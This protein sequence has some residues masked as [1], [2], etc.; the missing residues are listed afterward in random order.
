MMYNI[1]SEGQ[2]E[3][4]LF[5]SW[6]HKFSWH[7]IEKQNLIA[8]FRLIKKV[9]SPLVF[10]LIAGPVIGF[11]LRFFAS[12]YFLPDGTNVSITRMLIFFA[13]FGVLMSYV[14]YIT[15]TLPSKPLYTP[16][17]RDHRVAYVPMYTL[18]IYAGISLGIILFSDAASWISSI[19]IVSRHNIQ[20]TLA[21]C[22][23]LSLLLPVVIGIFIRLRKEVNRANKL[24]Y[25]S[26]LNQGLLEEHTANAQLRAL[27]A[28]INP[29]F[30]F[31]TLSSIVSLLSINTAVAKD[32]LLNLAEMHRYTL[33]C[34]HRKFVFLEEEIDFVKGYLSIEEV[35]FRDRLKIDIRI[36]EEI[37][38]LM[39]PGLVLQPIV[40]NAVKHGVA[41][42]IGSSKISVTVQQSEKNYTITVC[43]TT[44]NQPDLRRETCFV[45]GH[46]LK[47]VD[48]RL[49]AIYE[50][51]YRIDMEYAN[52]Q[53]CVKLR[54][55][56]AAHTNP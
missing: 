30:F 49:S 1:E 39:L 46:A 16:L 4:R 28:Q 54:I 20:A 42:N 32:M 5:V 10:G 36:A 29:H 13:C 11:T 33:M 53:V 22:L 7:K 37:D 41:G 25:E 17:R 55:P 15:Y 8:M 31:N 19:F 18:M 6:A 45:K 40:E 9:L 27:Q 12:G 14:C 44:E 21:V 34:T 52:D 43:N 3:K 23:I 47:N 51:R 48:D 26:N 24:L 38:H 56:K 2:A 50:S 35:R